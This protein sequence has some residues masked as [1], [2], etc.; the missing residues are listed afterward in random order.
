[1]FE[2]TRFYESVDRHNVYITVHDAVQH[3]MIVESPLFE[4]GPKSQKS[5]QN[6]MF[7]IIHINIILYK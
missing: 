7:V 1:M 3:S 6:Q 5:T 4:V 2:K